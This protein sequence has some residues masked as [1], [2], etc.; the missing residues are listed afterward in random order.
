[1][2]ESMFV[3]ADVCIYVFIYEKL[4]SKNSYYVVIL[5]FLMHI[6]YNSRFKRIVR[7]IYKVYNLCIYVY[8]YRRVY[9]RLNVCMYV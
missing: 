8:T 1:M 9:V 4:T 5:S 7:L 3:R 6:I 2:H